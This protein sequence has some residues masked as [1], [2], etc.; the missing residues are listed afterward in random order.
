VEFIYNRLY[1]QDSPINRAKHYLESRLSDVKRD[2]LT[3]TLMQM[4]YIQ[5]RHL[6][7]EFDEK[8]REA[9]VKRKLTIVSEDGSKF[10]KY[11]DDKM[12]LDDQLSLN[13]MTMS[14]YLYFREQETVIDIACWIVCQIQTHSYYDTLLD[15]VFQTEALLGMDCLVRKCREM[16]KIAITV[17][18]S[19]DNGEKRKLKIDST[20]MNVTQKFHFA[21]PVHQITY[22]VN[23]FGPVAVIICETFSEQEQKSVEPLPFQLTDE[24]TPMPWLTE[25]EAKT[26]LI[27]TPTHKDSQLAR[28][29]F[30]RTLV[31][32][33]QVPSGKNLV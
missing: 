14:L 27:Y 17:D 22:S 33:V 4:A 29:N 31:L 18:V 11:N 13:A 25:I 9:L 2:L 30:N 6:S 21:L 23:G 28:D 5:N 32:E 19:A 15:A 1:S 24:L 20:N 8:I 3:R 10:I 12:T 26:C 16:E 7:D